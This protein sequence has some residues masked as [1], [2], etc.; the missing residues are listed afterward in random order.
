MEIC[1]CSSSHVQERFTEGDIVDARRPGPAIGFKEGI[2]RIWLLI[3]GWEFQVYGNLAQRI[4]EPFDDS[5]AY[6]PMVDTYTMRDKRR[7]CIPFS[8]LQSVFPSFDPGQAR[9]LA[10][11][12]QPFYTL[13]EDNFFWL[14][15]KSPLPVAGLIFDK[16]NGVYL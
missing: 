4:G 16:A 6:D 12:Y 9:D 7:Y 2:T 5:G 15:D 14:T 3:Q 8:R 10:E 13:D 11:T 1:L